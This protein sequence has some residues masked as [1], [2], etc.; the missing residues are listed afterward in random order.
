MIDSSIDPDFAAFERQESFRGSVAVAEGRDST[1]RASRTVVYRGRLAAL[2]SHPDHQTGTLHS[3]TTTPD[4]DSSQ[5]DPLG[6]LRAA[7]LG[8]AA[9]VLLICYWLWIRKNRI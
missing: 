7:R 1:E 4:Y 8:F 5:P 9:V 6:H 3:T 2:A